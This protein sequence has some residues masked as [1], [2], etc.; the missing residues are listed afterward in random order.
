MISTVLF[1]RISYHK[2]NVY[3]LIPIAANVPNLGTSDFRASKKAGRNKLS[4]VSDEIV[5]SIH[6]G[7]NTVEFGQKT[8]EGMS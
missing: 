5:S 3:F 8:N 4:E 1:G 7:Y 2:K 6:N